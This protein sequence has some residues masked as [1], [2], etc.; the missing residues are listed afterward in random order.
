M[1]LAQKLM[2]VSS[3]ALDALEEP[4]LVYNF[5]GKDNTYEEHILAAAPVDVIRSTVVVA[6]IA[7]D[8]ATR[9]LEKDNG[10]LD[11]AVGVLDALSGNLAAAAELLR[12]RDETDV[13]DG[14]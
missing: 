1:E 11:E 9:I 10:G 4:Y 5:G 13:D 14:S 12:A 2:V 3:N 8:K 7:I 6:G